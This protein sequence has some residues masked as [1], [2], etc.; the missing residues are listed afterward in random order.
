MKLSEVQKKVLAKMSD[1][2]TYSAYTLQ[3]SLNTLYV[4]GRKGFIK[5]VDNG[6]GSSFDPRTAIQWQIIEEKK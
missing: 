3:C 5:R 2:T 4:M 6:L 1:G